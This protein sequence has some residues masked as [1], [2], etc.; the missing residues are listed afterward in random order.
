MN[1]PSFGF[2]EAS[3]PKLFLFAL[4]LIGD[5]EPANLHYKG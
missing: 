3:D 5:N 1:S 2:Q 4:E